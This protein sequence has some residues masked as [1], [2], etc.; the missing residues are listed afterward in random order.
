MQDSNRNSLENEGCWNRFCNK[1]KSL[2]SQIRGQTNR[3][4]NSNSIINNDHISQ[5]SQQQNVR[6]EIQVIGAEEIQVVNVEQILII[7]EIQQEQN[8]YLSDRKS[9]NNNFIV[10]P[11]CEQEMQ[12]DVYQIHLNMCEQQI[13]NC[14]L[15]EQECQ[16]CGQKIVKLYYNDHLDI[17]E[18][19]CWIQVKCPYCFIPVFKVDLYDHTQQCPIFLNQQNKEKEGIHNCTIC[20]E[21][22][23]Q[24]QTQLNCSHVF[25][26]DCIQNWLTQN[27]KC[28]ICK[29]PYIK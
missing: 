24:N 11:F 6:E 14:N 7:P 8:L 4:N 19:N 10:C 1:M 5:H 29:R 2:Y 9:L 20:L 16:Q 25:H 18:A 21:D 27:Q 15:I 23:I 13:G 28:P 22:I 17:C 3:R 26:E 12:E